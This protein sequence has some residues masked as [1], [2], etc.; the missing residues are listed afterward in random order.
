VAITQVD[1]HIRVKNVT[2]SI[3]W[4]QR[5]LG[6]KV[7]TAMPDR[8]RPSFVRLKQPDQE[9]ALMISDGSDFLTGKAPPKAT[10][11]AV[12]ARKAQRVVSLYFWGDLDVK[13]AHASAKRKGAKITQDVTDQPYGMREFEMQDPDGYRVGVGSVIAGA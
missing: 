10:Q 8:T 7:A 12:S 4:Y 11:D 13:R 5:M 3:E 6:F 1:V 2:R 9:W